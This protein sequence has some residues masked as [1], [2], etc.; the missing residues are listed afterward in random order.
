MPLFPPALVTPVAVL[1]G[2]TGQTTYTDG[3]L[4]I[5]NSSNSSLSKAALTAGTNV[6]ITNGNGTISIAAASGTSSFNV[7]PQTTTYNA[8][9]NDYIICSSASFTITLPTAVGQSGK[10][11]VIEHNGTNLTQVYTLNTTSAQ[12]IGGIASGSY[13]LYTTGET[14]TL[15][16]DGANW[17]I[18]DHKTETGWIDAGATT[19]TGTSSNPTKPTGGNVVRDKVYWRRFGTQC[20]IRMEYRQTASTGAADG[21][22]SYVF[23]LPVTIDTN[24]V[25]TSNVANTGGT[26]ATAAVTGVGYG[27]WTNTSARGGLMALAFDSTHITLYDTQNGNMIQNGSSG[28][29]ATDSIVA[30]SINV[31]VPVLNWQP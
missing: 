25:T 8:T 1:K 10:A 14:L 26:T 16:S 6:T 15:V 17:Q 28:G 12:T 13:A 24:F 18:Q 31:F 30:I 7:T 11:I 23:L 4:L 27:M 21:S 20:Q 5:G 9:I 2:G 3:Q 22:G 29:L 19:I